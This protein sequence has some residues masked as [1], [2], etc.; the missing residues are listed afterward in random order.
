MFRLFNN[1]IKKDSIQECYYLTHIEN[2][3]S[4]LQRG[5]LSHRRVPTLSIK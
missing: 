2:I 3:S 5:I 1:K 4:I